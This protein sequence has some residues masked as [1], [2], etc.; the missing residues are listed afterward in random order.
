MCPR[1][2]GLS[3][4]MVA[5]C[6]GNGRPRGK[7]GGREGQ[8]AASWGVRAAAYQELTE[9][10]P[11]FKTLAARLVEDSGEGPLLDLGA[12]GG[13]V[14]QLALARCPGRQ[15]TL[16]EPV[17]EMHAFALR[18]LAPLGPTILS[19]AAEDLALPRGSLG[20]VLSSAAFHLVREDEA[21]PRIAEALRDGGLLAF[22]LW[23]HSFDQTARE[24]A[25]SQIEGPIRE[26]LEQCGCA[27]AELPVGSPPRQR[28]ARDIDSIGAAHDLRLEDVQVDRDVVARRFFVEFAALSPAFLADLGDELRGEVIAR[29]CE[30]ADDPV[31]VPSVRIRMR[32]ESR[33]A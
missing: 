32:R 11:L 27:G 4:S 12:G 13:L 33:G 10:W 20:A 22:N 19:C 14:S 7:R 26:A 6:S 9:R 3:P 8:A 25:G 24:L 2:A 30:L 17:R 5:Q 16:L 15:V 28:S 1:N 18:R 21:L 23:W 31:T 29:A